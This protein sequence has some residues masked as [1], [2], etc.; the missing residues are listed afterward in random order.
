MTHKPWITNFVW[1]N[2]FMGI[3][4]DTMRYAFTI[5]REHG[6][7]IILVIPS[8]VQAGIGPESILQF[9]LVYDETTGLAELV[10]D[11]TYSPGIES[12]GL[13]DKIDEARKWVSDANELLEQGRKR[14][15][16]SEL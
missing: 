2:L 12:L 6:D 3:D 8:R 10:L 9:R 16:L 13:T 11:V 4:W 15:S 14:R 5:S 1:H 7:A